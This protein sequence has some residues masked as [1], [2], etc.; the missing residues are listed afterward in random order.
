MGIYFEK[1]FNDYNLHTNK[2]LYFEYSRGDCV[3]QQCSVLLEA[4][5]SL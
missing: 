2:K 4:T 5:C 1:K 3:L